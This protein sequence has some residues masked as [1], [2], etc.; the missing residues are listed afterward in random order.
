MGQWEGLS[1]NG[2][3]GVE[4]G[5]RERRGAE[6]DEYVTGEKQQ[7]VGQRERGGGQVVMEWVMG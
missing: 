5:L 3:V 1:R 4:W 7:R 2:E 6:D